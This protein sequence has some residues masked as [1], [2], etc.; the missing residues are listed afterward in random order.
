MA[1]T[2]K[3]KSAGR[4]GARYG[5]TIRT[6]VTLIESQL[7]KWHTCPHCFR[8]RVK[9]VAAGIWECRKCKIKFAGGAYIPGV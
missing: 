6:K 9:R 4:F 8:K 7:K 5:R 3:V 1:H 2:K